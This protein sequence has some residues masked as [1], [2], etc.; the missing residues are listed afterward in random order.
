MH[1]KAHILPLLGTLCPYDP[2][3]PLLSLLAGPTLALFNNI[4]IAPD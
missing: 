3:T 1:I 2:V 4:P